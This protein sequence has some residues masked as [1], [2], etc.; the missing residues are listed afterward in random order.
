MV[1]LLLVRLCMWWEE[2]VIVEIVWEGKW[3]IIV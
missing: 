1:I 3:V 2:L